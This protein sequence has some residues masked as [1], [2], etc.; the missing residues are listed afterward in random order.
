MPPLSK[1]INKPPHFLWHASDSIKNTDTASGAI[2]S[3]G[4]EDNSGAILPNISGYH[5]FHNSNCIMGSPDSHNRTDLFSWMSGYPDLLNSTVALPG[6]TEYKGGYDAIDMFSSLEK[7]CDVLASTGMLPGNT[8]YHSILNSTCLLP[9]GTIQNG[10]LNT[11]GTLS[12]VSGSLRLTEWKI[13]F[14]LLVLMMIVMTFVG[15]TFVIASIRLERR[16]QTPTN[17]LTLS[18]AATDLLVAVLV[19]PLS[20]INVLKHDIV[21]IPFVCHLWIILDVNLCSVSIFHLLVIAVDRYRSVTDINYQCKRST[22]KILGMITICWCVGWVICSPLIFGVSDPKYDPS[23][24]GECL[25][26]QSVIYTLFSTIFAFYIPAMVMVSIYYKIFRIAKSSIRKTYFKKL[27][28]TDENE[29]R[30]SSAPECLN[31]SK[32]RHR[33]SFANIRYHFGR[34]RASLDSLRSHFSSSRGSIGS[35]HV[36]FGSSRQ[37]FDSQHV[38]HGRCNSRTSLDNSQTHRSSISSN[39]RRSQRSVTFCDTDSGCTDCRCSKGNNREKCGCINDHHGKI[40]GP[41]FVNH[42]QKT[43]ITDHGALIVPSQASSNN[44]RENFGVFHANVHDRCENSGCSRPRFGNHRKTVCYSQARFDKHRSDT[45]LSRASIDGRCVSYSESSFVSRRKSS[46]ENKAA[47]EF[48]LEQISQSNDKPIN[49]PIGNA[50]PFKR[51]RA[52]LNDS[53]SFKMFTIGNHTTF[54]ENSTRFSGHRSNVLNLDEEKRKHESKRERRAA[55]TLGIITGAFIMCWLPFFIVA[56]ISPL[57]KNKDVT[58]P[59]SVQTFVLWLGYF[60]CLV[61]PFIYTVF[62]EEFRKAFKKLASCR[63]CLK[64]RFH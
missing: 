33:S 2:F 1:F 34:S 36:Q 27:L 24:T 26:D 48:E 6:N 12:D 11:T 31:S 64:R 60:N 18:L 23:I 13:A 51:R 10:S 39:S 62:N 35:H 32:R 56:L 43:S 4:F 55:R 28:K 9:G 42:R 38:N 58:I 49:I 54:D 30:R 3:T 53:R 47:N 8:E 45:V 19:M 20:V 16:L 57:I 61:N 40:E 37:S 29:I 44:Q 63:Y 22:H 21:L 50:S 5:G 25:I 59:Q 17:Y 14:L 15:N 46:T 52:V 41:G 7:I